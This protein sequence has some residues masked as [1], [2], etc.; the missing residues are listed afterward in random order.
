MVWNKCHIYPSREERYDDSQAAK[1]KVLG[2]FM[3]RINMSCLIIFTFYSLEV[4]PKAQRENKWE[5]SQKLISILH[6]VIFF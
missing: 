4:S 3:S 5:T 6:T 1:P 2:R